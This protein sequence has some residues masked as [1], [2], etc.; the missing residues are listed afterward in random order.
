MS[1]MNNKPSYYLYI[2]A[3]DI[4]MDAANNMSILVNM[5][6]AVK[7]DSLYFQGYLSG[8]QYAMALLNEFR[9]KDGENGNS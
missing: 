6:A 1:T 3:I 7:Q 5:S 2:D 4:L 9:G 8:L